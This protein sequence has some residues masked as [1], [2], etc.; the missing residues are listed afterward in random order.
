M[1]PE[2]MTS[3]IK[4]C[5]VLKTLPWYPVNTVS[6]NF[7]PNDHLTCQHCNK[8][9]KTETGLNRHNA[10]CKE[11]GKLSDNNEHNIPSTI[12]DNDTTASQT[13]EYPWLQTGDK[14]S[15][16]TIDIIYDKV[17]F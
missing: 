8:T 10:K 2:N 13:T 17:V 1:V 14:I 4:L 6:Q 9:C 3:Q 16:N 11:R 7:L 5:L 12:N 15:S